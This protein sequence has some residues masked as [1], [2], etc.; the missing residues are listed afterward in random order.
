MREYETTIVLRT[1]LE[2]AELEKEIQTVESGITGKGGE[3]VQLER[4]GKRRL[5]YEI[6]RQHEGYY[7]MFRYTAIAEVPAD[8]EK[9]FR[10]NERLLRHLTVIA[11][12]PR[13][14]PRD[15]EAE[16]GASGEAPAEAGAAPAASTLSP[17]PS[18]EGLPS[19]PGAGEL[20]PVTAGDES[21]LAHESES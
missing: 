20:S 4:W 16:S 19:S 13:P 17:G 11:D 3:I 21:P 15:A 10:I 9:R 14:R 1:N 7:V 8:L 6:E 5:A 18:G 2:E 12:T